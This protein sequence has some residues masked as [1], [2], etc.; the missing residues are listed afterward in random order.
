[1]QTLRVGCEL[2]LY[3]KATKS[4]NFEENGKQEQSFYALQHLYFMFTCVC[5][6]FFYMYF[7]LCFLLEKK[8]FIIILNWWKQQ[9]IKRKQQK[10]CQRNENEKLCINKHTGFWTQHKKKEFIYFFLQH[11][12]TIQHIRIIRRKGAKFKCE[13]TMFVYLRV[14]IWKEKQIIIK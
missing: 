2:L 1:M 4:T 12:A 3:I 11:K 8:S 7:T 6:P 13:R 9:I 5:L 14:F 10:K